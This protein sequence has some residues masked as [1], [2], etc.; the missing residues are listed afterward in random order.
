MKNKTLLVSLG[1]TIA[2]VSKF[3]QS[4]SEVRME[5]VLGSVGLARKHSHALEN[6][7]LVGAGAILGTG[8]ALLWVPKSGRE[9]RA[10]LGRQAS[11]LGQEAWK[12]GQKASRLGQTATA[13]LTAHEDEALRSVSQSAGKVAS[14]NGE[15]H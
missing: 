11:K 1:A 12:V 2:A 14:A 9:T 10:L 15:H 13:V 8:A 6:L 7:A 3:V 4:I 5:N